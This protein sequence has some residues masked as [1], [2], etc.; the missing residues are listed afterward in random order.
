MDIYKDKYGYK[1]ITWN[2]F[3]E[4]LFWDTFS[5]HILIIK[6][7]P[8][9]SFHI[10]SYPFISY[11]ILGGELPDVLHVLPNPLSQLCGQP[12]QAPV[13]RLIYVLQPIWRG[14]L[15][16]WHSQ[17]ASRILQKLN[18]AWFEKV[19][20]KVYT[21]SRTSRAGLYIRVYQS[22][23]TSEIRMVQSEQSK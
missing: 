2:L 6:R 21:T 19:E 22:I 12:A 23:Y 14:C 20:V 17:R 11:N 4:Y 1:E 16:V 3:L 13:G 7:Y 8:I 15:S 18:P 5:N 9:I 10:L